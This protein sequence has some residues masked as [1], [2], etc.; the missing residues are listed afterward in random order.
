MET[1][2]D[3]GSK[4]HTYMVDG[5]VWIVGEQKISMWSK[6][7]CNQPIKIKEKNEKDKEKS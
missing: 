1:N 4:G 2:K 7:K 6:A 3:A 5:K